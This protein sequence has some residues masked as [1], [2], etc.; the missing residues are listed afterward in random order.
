MALRKYS[1]KNIFGLDESLNAKISFSAIMASYD[2]VANSNTTTT[3]P[4]TQSI[5]ELKAQ[6]DSDI[7]DAKQAAQALIDDTVTSAG[8][9][10]WSVDKIKEFVASVDDTV[11]VQDI[12]ARD[13]LNAY[14]TLIAFVLDTSDDSD[15]GEEAGKPHAYIYVDGAWKLLAPLG[16]HIDTTVFILKESIVNDYTTGGEDKVL[17][18]E[19][20]KQIVN[21]AIPNAINQK[22]V[23]I[24]T[25][26][27]TV[28][29]NKIAT[30]VNPVGN[31]VFGCVEVSTDEGIEVVDASVTGDKEV[32]L[33]PDESGKYDGKK[34]RVTY[35][36]RT[37]E[38]SAAESDD[39]NT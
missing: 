4:S 2:D 28:D 36:A 31:I 24:V 30:L 27:V 26:T 5:V 33:S 11:V 1:R 25:E 9:K 18:A 14:D 39:S 10:T 38:V 21:V 8:D 34:A 20:G 15:L 16:E 19:A 35:L 37:V 23:R 7:N 12:S 13:E 32:T 6:I 22:D 29:S 17:S 3:V